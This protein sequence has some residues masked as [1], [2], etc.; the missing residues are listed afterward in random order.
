MKL[1]L[2]AQRKSNRSLVSTSLDK[3][4]TNDKEKEKGMYFKRLLIII[5]QHI[6]ILSCD[7]SP[8][9]ELLDTL[10]LTN[11]QSYMLLLE[12]LQTLTQ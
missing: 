12:L 5:I 4:K 3:N 2:A 11:S 9:K 1:C 10:C 6:S 8:H 7:S